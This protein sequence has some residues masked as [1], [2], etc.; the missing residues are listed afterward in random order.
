[1]Y[2]DTFVT[3]GSLPLFEDPIMQLAKYSNAVP[4]V[5]MLRQVANLDELE[6]TNKEYEIHCQR[7][8]T[9]VTGLILYFHTSHSSR[10]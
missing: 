5:A 7:S 10:K 3:G 6:R 9:N 8:K 4:Q 2:G 1:L